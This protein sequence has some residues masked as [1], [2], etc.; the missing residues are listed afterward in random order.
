MLAGTMVRRENAMLTKL[1]TLICLIFVG[2]IGVAT[3]QVSQAAL[4]DTLLKGGDVASVLAQIRSLSPQNLSVE[5]RSALITRLQQLN[6]RVAEVTKLDSTVDTFINPETLIELSQVVAELRDRRAIP[7]LSR[8]PDGGPVVIR[9][10]VEFGEQALPAITSVVLSP[11]SHY[12]EV[13]HGLLTMRIMVQQ[14]MLSPTALGQIRAAT[15]TR[16]FGEQYFTVVWQAIDLAAALKDPEL[17]QTLRELA[18]YPSESHRRGITNAEVPDLVE[19][20]QKRAADRLAGIP[21]KPDVKMIFATAEP[22]IR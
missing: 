22:N 13:E 2:S 7:A 3:A 18:E 11:S 1:F 21:A 6:Q 10:L 20:T 19:R 16:L 12:T 17:D 4:A 9:A 5:L 15:K 8:S 14:G